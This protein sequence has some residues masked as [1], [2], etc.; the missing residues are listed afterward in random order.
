M[1]LIC[2]IL[3][4]DDYRLL[5]F[6]EDSRRIYDQ[7][8]YHMRHI[9]FETKEQGRIRTYSYNELYDL[10]KD[11][12]SFKD[13][14]LDFVAKQY[15]IKQVFNSWKSFIKAAVE[16]KRNPDKFIGKPQIVRYLYK[17][18]KYNVLS[19][20]KTRFSKKGCKENEIKIP[21]T[22]F[23]IKIPEYI[24]RNTIR[25]IRIMK[26]FDR[27]KIEIVYEIP[28]KENRS[29]NSSSVGIDIGLNNLCAIT[30]ND[31]GLSYVINGRPLKSMNQYFNKKKARLQGNNNFKDLKVLSRKHRN[32]TDNYLH[33]CSRQIVN[34]CLKHNIDNIVIG[35][36]KEWKQ[37]IRLG[38]NTNQNFVSIPFNRLIEQLK[39][40]GQ[41]E[42]INV[43][44]TEESYTSKVD[45]LAFEP[46]K[47]Q[48]TYLGKRLKRGLFQSSTGK[49]LNADI[50]GAIGILRKTNAILDEELLLLQDRGD[51]V[52]P[53][54]LEKAS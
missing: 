50:N 42:G 47:R 12:S 52:S 44:I 1:K 53:K 54:R 17:R 9:Y 35:H 28:D 5:G 16:Y 51:V 49:I 15:S 25:Q 26:Y 20:D 33:W 6:L 48:E 22:E 19:F 21:K 23:K 32:K 34:L 36:N 37:N 38:K 8:L 11:S 18:T 39:Y 10:V 7:A 40:K 3:V 27:I 46:M 14:D 31:K 24:D 2:P 41:V 4:K 29:L 13:S 30:S 45:H 43:V